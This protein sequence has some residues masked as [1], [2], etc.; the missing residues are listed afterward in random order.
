MSIDLLP[1]TV[2]RPKEHVEF[3]QF[4]NGIRTEVAIF[5]G[6]SLPSDC[7]GVPFGGQPAVQH[8]RAKR[9]DANL[10]ASGYESRKLERFVRQNSNLIEDVDATYVS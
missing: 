6:A 7:A 8:V 3:L 4:H 2:L 10:L 5:F 1:E 9:R